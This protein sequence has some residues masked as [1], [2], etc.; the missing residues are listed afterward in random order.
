[1]DKRLEEENRRLVE[2]LVS[3]GYIT[4]KKVKEAFLKVPR[5][6]F[7]PKKYLDSTYI[8]T[9]LPLD[10]ES[11][12]SAFHM[13]AMMTELLDVKKGQRILEVGAGSGWQAC[14]LGYLVGKKGLVVTIEINKRVYEFAKKNVKKLDFKNVKVVWGDGSLGYPKFAPYDR[15]LVTAACPFAIPKP[16]IEQLKDNGRLVAPVEK[17]FG[18][19][20]L[21]LLKKINGKIETERIIGVAFVRLKGKYGFD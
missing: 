10:K 17:E 3:S 7:V 20:E 2:Y 13:V 12:I 8:D 4:S 19:Q 15:I 6:L 5:H 1:M 11:T 9:P 18:E 14:I 21:I 16:L